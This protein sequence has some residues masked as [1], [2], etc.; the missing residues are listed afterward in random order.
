MAEIRHR[1]HYRDETQF[2][3][4]LLSDISRELAGYGWDGRTWEQLTK[5]ASGD[6][7]FNND[8]RGNLR[9]IAGALERLES[10]A[11]SIAEATVAV[12]IERKA[13][14]PWFSREAQVAVMAGLAEL[15]KRYGPCPKLARSQFQDAAWRAGRAD[16]LS[17][18]G[19]GSIR[20]NPARDVDHQLSVAHK[21]IMSMTKRAKTKKQYIAWRKLED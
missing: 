20:P 9:R 8:D 21:K 10:L 13:S 2:G 18:W 14:E 11:R 3:F 5:L 12:Q 7:G 6:V 19:D 1:R 16:R 4:T 15:E 17:Y